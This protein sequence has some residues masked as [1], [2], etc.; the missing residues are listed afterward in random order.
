MPTHAANKA[1]KLS[2]APMMDGDDLGCN[3]ISDRKISRSGEFPMYDWTDCL[4][5]LTVQSVV[6]SL[7]EW[8][9]RKTE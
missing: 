8:T 6:R 3:S 1:V 2:V 5:E 7:V 9:L 4:F